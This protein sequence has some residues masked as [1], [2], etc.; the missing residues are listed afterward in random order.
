[1]SKPK[2]KI[3]QIRLLLPAEWVPELDNLSA[4]RFLTRLGFLRFLIRNGI[5]QELANLAEHF[6]QTEQQ[7][8]T[9]KQIQQR[10]QD[11]EW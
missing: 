2:S 8:K 11:S 10:R 3:T 1:M 4:T 5:N 7:R 6:K 9:H